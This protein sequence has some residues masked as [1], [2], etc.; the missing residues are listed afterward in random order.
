M[1]WSPLSNYLLYGETAD[2]TAAKA[3]GVNIALGSDWAPSGSK[4]LSRRGSKVAWLASREH[5]E[6]V[7][8]G[9]TR[10]DGHGER[11]PRGQVGL[12]RSGRSSRADSADLVA[13]NGQH[14]DPYEQLLRARGDVG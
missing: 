6:C 2:M 11:G 9:G 5:G 1:V 3:A 10:G 13:V 12:A 14:E 8:A 7:H 4:K